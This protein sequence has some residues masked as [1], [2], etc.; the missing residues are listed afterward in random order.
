M[1]YLAILLCVLQAVDIFTTNKAIS[2]GAIETNKLMKFCQERLDKFW[3]LPKLLITIA[4]CAILILFVPAKF[5]FYCLICFNIFYMVIIFNN[6]NV[7]R[8]QH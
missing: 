5:C 1:F 7:I 2:F 8:R 4:I 3:F 6:F